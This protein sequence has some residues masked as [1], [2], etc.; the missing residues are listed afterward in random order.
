[1]NLAFTVLILIL[2]SLTVYGREPNCPNICPV[3]DDPVCASD[4]ETYP[5][6]CVL[7]M[8]TCQSEDITKVHHGPCKI[9]CPD[10]CP[11]IYDP[12]CASDGKTYSNDCDLKIKT[13]KSEDITKVHHGPCKK[14]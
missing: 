6:D 5:N 14:R 9:N 1:M 7:K 4:G 10:I 8:T 13:C 12:V 11:A 3:I 2:L